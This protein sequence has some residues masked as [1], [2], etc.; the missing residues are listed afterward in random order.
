MN[1]FLAELEAK[2]YRYYNYLNGELEQIVECT[3]EEVEVP[4]HQYIYTQHQQECNGTKTRKMINEIW[5]NDKLTAEDLG[6]IM[7]LL[8]DIDYDTIDFTWSMNF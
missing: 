6:D 1:K 7:F 8:T 3:D 5:T 2:G 4:A